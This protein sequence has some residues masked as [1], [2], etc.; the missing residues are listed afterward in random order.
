MLVMR[1]IQFRHDIFLNCWR[2]LGSGWKSCLAMLPPFFQTFFRLDF[3]KRKNFLLAEIVYRFQCLIETFQLADVVMNLSSFSEIFSP[4]IHQKME[5]ALL[6]RSN[7]FSLFNKAQARSV[8]CLSLF[9]NTNSMNSIV[10]FVKQGP[11][12]PGDD[13]LLCFIH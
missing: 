1:P 13:F 5:K 4:L 2:T 12:F 11:K 10:F 7:F 8:L 3:C 6:A 9:L